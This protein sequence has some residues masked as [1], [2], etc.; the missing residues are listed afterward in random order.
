MQEQEIKEK[1]FLTPKEAAALMGVTPITVSRYVKEGKLRAL[2]TMGG[3]NRFDR[4]EILKLVEELQV[5][6]AISP[7]SDKEG[8]Y[9]GKAK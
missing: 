8:N 2:K 3:Q 7:H 5:H 6:I 1:V 4:A 9:H